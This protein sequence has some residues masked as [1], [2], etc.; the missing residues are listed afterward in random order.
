MSPTSRFRLHALLPI[1]TSLLALSACANPQPAAPPLPS[2]KTTITLTP[3]DIA[4]IQKLNIMNIMQSATAKSAK[5]NA[6]RNDLATLGATIAQDTTSQQTALATLVAPHAI[7]LPTTAPKEDQTLIKRLQ[8]LHG[9]A[10]DR[11]YIRYLTH[12]AAQMKPVLD[13]EILTSSNTDLIKLARE[14]KARLSAY[15]EQIQ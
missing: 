12:E 1:M 3:G 9:P 14:T 2:L 15:Q 8:A 11:L 4:F 6:G 13:T 10:F 7:T 5:S